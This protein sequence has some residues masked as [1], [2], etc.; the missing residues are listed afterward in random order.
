M[1]SPTQVNLSWKDNS[2]N[3]TGFVIERKTR[4]APTPPSPP[5]AQAAAYSDATAWAS[6]QYTYRVA[7]T[8]SSGN[9]AYSNEAALTT[10]AAEVTISD[11]SK[12]EGNGKGTTSFAFTVTLSRPSSQTVTLQYAT[13]AGTAT[14]G[15]DYVAAGG[16]LTF[17]QGKTSQAVTV[18]VV[19]DKVKEADE[20]FFVDLTGVVN[21]LIKKSRGVGTILNDD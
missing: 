21:A 10:S 13:T 15:S 16:T 3:E 11:V 8:S 2:T 19:R 9:S 6:T 12:Q 17:A 1:D 7:A 18:Q 20:T 4:P 14:A 5:S